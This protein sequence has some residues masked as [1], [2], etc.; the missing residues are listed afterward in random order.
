M[1]KESNLSAKHQLQDWLS[2]VDFSYMVTIQCDKKNEMSETELNQRLR[3]FDYKLPKKYLVNRFTKLPLESRIWCIGFIESEKN[4]Y[5]NWIDDEGL[6]K[7]CEYPKYRNETAMFK[8]GS[9]VGLHQHILVFVPEK[10]STSFSSRLSPLATNFIGIDLLFTWYSIPSLKPGG[11]RRKIQPPHI[12]RIDKKRKESVVRYASK[13]IK[14]TD[15]DSMNIAP[16]TFD[17]RTTKLFG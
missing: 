3:I 15:L 12:M 2:S 10:N 6:H 11:F 14:S 5:R 8:N 17:Y 16:E 4:S 13:H 7:F 9:D 1:N